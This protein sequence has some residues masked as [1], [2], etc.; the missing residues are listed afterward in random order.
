MVKIKMNVFNLS[1]YNT[2]NRK[3]E[4]VDKSLRILHRK[5]QLLFVHTHTYYTS[6][7]VFVSRCEHREHLSFLTKYTYIKI[8]MLFYFYFNLILSWFSF[9]IILFVYI[10]IYILLVFRICRLGLLFL[11]ILGKYCTENVWWYVKRKFYLK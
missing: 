5:F 4:K 1:A 9:W 6:E 3:T 2:R 11:I 8:H 7:T 10:C